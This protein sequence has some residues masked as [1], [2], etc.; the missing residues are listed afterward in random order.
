MSKENEFL[1]NAADFFFL[2]VVWRVGWIRV[3][4]WDGV[5]GAGGSPQVFFFHRTLD[6]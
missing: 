6:W 3:M 1:E 2:M 4:H 5:C